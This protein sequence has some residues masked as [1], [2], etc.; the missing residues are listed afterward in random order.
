MV[1]WT[2]IAVGLVFN[3]IIAAIIGTII[4]YI[5][6]KIAKIED[7]TIMKTFIAA[8]IAV[9]LNIVLGLAVLGIAGSAVT[10]FVIASSLGRFIA[11]ILV[12]P[13]I[14]IVYATTWIKAFI[15]WIIYIVGSFVISFVIGI[16]LA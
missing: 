16:A 11:W 3:L 4:L 6:A 15:A 1:D 12:I 10:G 13:V 7:A 14:K 9:I 5:A 2:I 8:L